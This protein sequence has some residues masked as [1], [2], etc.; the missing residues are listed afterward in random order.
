MSGRSIAPAGKKRPR[1][2]RKPRK[3]PSIFISRSTP[4]EPPGDSPVRN[5]GFARAL[6]DCPAPAPRGNFYSHCFIGSIYY[7]TNNR[8]GKK[9]LTRRWPACDPWDS[10]P[11]SCTWPTAP[12]SSAGLH[13]AGHG[14]S[15]RDSLW[16]PS[17]FRALRVESGNG[18]EISVRPVLSFRA[19]I[20]SIKDL[21]PGS[22]VGLQRAVDGAEPLPRGRARGGIRRWAGCACFPIRPRHRSRRARSHCRHVSMDLTTAD[23]TGI[24]SA[25][26]GRYRHDLRHRQR[27]DAIRARRRENRQHRQCGAALRARKRVP[28]FLFA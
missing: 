7:G 12:R 4:N 21:P 14:A 28:R 1:Q 17:I 15:R 10:I 23:V 9:V 2:Q 22:R 27:H 16:L 13:L 25:R 3:R 18:S 20:V 6:G 8:A 5:S 26:V 19:R 24:A 11:A